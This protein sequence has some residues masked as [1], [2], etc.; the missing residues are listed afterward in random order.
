[1]EENFR[2][3]KP[4]IR[5][6]FLIFLS[7][8]L[9]VMVAKKY[10]SYTIS[11]YESTTKLKLADA[12]K[13]IESSNLFKDFDVFASANKIAAEIEVIKSSILLNKALDSIDFDVEVYR[14]GRL[15]VVELY[16]NSPFKIKGD[17]NDSKAFD[18]KYGLKIC[19]DKEFEIIIPD[20]DQTLIIGKFGE[21]VFF[22]YGHFILSLNQKY[23]ASKPDCNLID[24]YEFEFLS[25][26]K[27]ISKI[28]K[29][30]DIVA[31]DKDVAIIRINFKSP[32]PAKASL[33][34]NTLAK[35]YIADYIESKY[36][37][38]ETT[39]R[40]LDKQL[41]EVS[42]KLS[43]TESNIENYRNEQKITN[44]RQ[45]TET[46]LRKISQLKIQQTNVK[47]NLLAIQSLNEY[48]QKGKD[49]FLELAPNFEAF[50]DLL[51]TEIIKSIKNLQSEKKD[52]LL[53]YT[54]EEERVQVI[55]HKINDLTSYLV[56]SIANTKR[57]L[58]IKYLN[59]SKDI[60]EFEKVFITVPEKE[61]M[62]TVMN[63]EFEIYQKIY[64]SLNE[65]KIEAGIA[66]AAKISFHRIIN[67]AESSN[68]PVSPNR[69]I[70]I[71]V[72]GIMGMFGSIVLIHIIHLAKAKVN[73]RQ[74]IESNSGIPIAMLT[75]KLKSAQAIE[76]HFLQEA[77]QLEIKD[78]LNTKSILCLSSFKL[79]EGA[80]F[81]SLHLAK[82][83]ASQ[84]RKVL[85]VD[86]AD[87]MQSGENDSS[88]PV[89]IQKNLNLII[90]TNPKFKSFTKIRMK[91]FFDKFK[92]SYDTIL[93]LNED[94]GK[95]KYL[96]MMS[97]AN[98][99]LIILDAR[100]THAKKIVEV[101]L[102]K[103]EYSLP[104]VQ[105]ILNRY[106]YNPS[107]LKEIWI[108]FKKGLWGKKSKP[109]LM[110]SILTLSAI[111]LIGLM[112]FLTGGLGS[113]S[114]SMN[115]NLKSDDNIDSL[116]K[117][118][119]EQNISDQSNKSARLFEKRISDR[120]QNLDISELDTRRTEIGI[121]VQ[122]VSKDKM[123]HLIIGSFQVLKNAENLAQSYRKN[124]YDPKIIFQ[125]KTQ[126]HLVSIGAY[127]QKSTAEAESIKISEVLNT[128]VW[129]L[130]Y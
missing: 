19:S 47:M 80:L 119:L 103:E 16:D 122:N 45:E 7:M 63:R 31:V 115:Y 49:N 75:P 94:L 117:E 20:N 90:L 92:E 78:L 14:K 25:R 46:D 33:L 72:A 121:T 113:M 39:V 101:D 4:F 26:Q 62:I 64:V 82:A 79:K 21:P 116:N 43:R 27:L 59:L 6:S 87:T 66:K 38:A 120:N 52:L 77:G 44:I 128:E 118:N 55:D 76:N 108:L 96:L 32:V 68:N 83:L 22:K 17:F 54:P 109:W 67:P 84:G 29:N 2:F 129:I 130:K 85:L 100:L 88:V 30:L 74:T 11:M 23:I 61:K 81:N 70:I 107:V 36:K 104:N 91:G 125:R 41:V 93:I 126:W 123:Y 13:G 12:N 95:Q 71:I 73:D 124:N 10:L 105:F 57:S 9:A 89:N 99:N 53:I 3:L 42:G 1:M 114:N 65:K 28:S 69:P 111:S 37:A 98:T 48:I 106:N 51:S 97:I 102:F 86:V 8:V 40:F 18:K 15:K 60:E 112:M 50:T 5:G 35:T 127:I 58:E 56:E 110:R 24:Q 34:V